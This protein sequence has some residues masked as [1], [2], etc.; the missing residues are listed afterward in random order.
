MFLYLTINK[1]YHEFYFNLVDVN[2]LD[3]MGIELMEGRFFAEAF[4]TDFK[5]AV[6]VNEA[7]VKEFIK[8]KNYLK[9]KKAKKVRTN[10]IFGGKTGLKGV[11]SGR[12]EL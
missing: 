5:E 11:P 6:V 10:T 4:Q 1:K 3:V 2:Y 9:Q 12:N 8:M 7:F